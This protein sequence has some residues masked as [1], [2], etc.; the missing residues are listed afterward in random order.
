[1]SSDTARS[2]QHRDV[3]AA[4]ERRSVARCRPTEPPRAVHLERRAP[5]VAP[6]RRR[7]RPQDP[8]RSAPRRRRRLRR[9]LRLTGL[10]PGPIPRREGNAVHRTCRRLVIRAGFAAIAG[11]TAFL[12]RS[13]AGRGLAAVHACPLRACLRVRH[14]SLTVGFQAVGAHG[15]GL[16]EPVTAELVAADSPEFQ[17]VVV[18]VVKET[19]GLGSRAERRDTAGT[20]HAGNRQ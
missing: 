7:A 12:I 11:E 10:P 6:E 3:D 1:V 2:A 18:G 9:S 17:L 5:D 16:F 19:S 15:E 13:P 20:V 4:C 8:P 14:A